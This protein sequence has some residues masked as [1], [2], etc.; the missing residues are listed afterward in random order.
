[1]DVSKTSIR[2]AAGKFL[3]LAFQIIIMNSYQPTSLLLDSSQFFSCNFKTFA[4]I[5]IIL[6]GPGEKVQSLNGGNGS[7][8]IRV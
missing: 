5:N 6:T 1:M 4:N 7:I 8:D 3:F 2:T